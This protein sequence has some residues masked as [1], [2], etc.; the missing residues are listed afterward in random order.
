MS[1]CLLANTTARDLLFGYLAP[2]DI[3][4]A[5]RANRKLASSALE[6]MNGLRR[7]VGF[8]RRYRHV[9]AFLLHLF[10][11]H[12][13]N[14][15]VRVLGEVFPVCKVVAETPPDV[16][17]F[18]SLDKRVRLK[19]G[20]F[21]ADIANLRE[22]YR[23][24]ADK[25]R[26]VRSEA[27]FLSCVLTNAD[28]VLDPVSAWDHI[29]RFDVYDAGSA[30]RMNVERFNDFACVFLA[31]FASAAIYRRTGTRYIGLSYPEVLQRVRWRETDLGRA[32]RILRGFVDAV[33]DS[34][35]RVDVAP[36]MTYYAG[37]IA[38]LTPQLCLYATGYYHPEHRVFRTLRYAT[39][40]F[41]SPAFHPRDVCR[42]FAKRNFGKQP[43]DDFVRKL[44]MLRSKRVGC[45]CFRVNSFCT[46][47]F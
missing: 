17:T 13:E 1:T 16:T 8:H 32:Q 46:R 37:F 39:S 12:P 19:L 5:I 27:D 36:D 25:I 2:A 29:E 31:E 47:C 26:P 9:L 42:S 44:R 34:A 28:Q 7:T 6:S 20:F 10:G 45:G 11:T 18:E 23:D 15:T 4:N 3:C 33:C 21:R 38:G 30:F 41:R 22:A 40:C 43:Y 14:F 24:N 35:E